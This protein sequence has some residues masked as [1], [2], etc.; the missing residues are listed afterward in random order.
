MTPTRENAGIGVSVGLII[1]FAATATLA[2]SSLTGDKRQLF[3]EREKQVRT[4]ASPIP[5][6]ARASPTAPD[7][8]PYADPAAP[9]KADRLA[10]REKPLL[11]TP[12]SVTVLTRKI[13]DDKN[14]TTLNEIGRS[15]AGVTLGIR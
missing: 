11:N 6:P 5:A 3:R 15:T 7:R 13:L 4:A 10:S 2:Q 9:Y 1:S 8:D 14:A 12:G